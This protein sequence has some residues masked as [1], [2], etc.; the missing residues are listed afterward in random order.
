MGAGRSFLNS[1]MDS[2]PAAVAYLDQELIF[3]QC[4]QAAAREL[5]LPAAEMLGRHLHEVLPSGSRL[6]A[7][8]ESVL[9]SGEP[10]PEPVI[11]D[12]RP[13]GPGGGERHY[14]VGFLPDKDAAGGVRGVFAACQDITDVVE[15]RRRLAEQAQLRL[16]REQMQEFSRWLLEGQERQARAIAMELHDESGQALTALMLALGARS[17]I[18]PARP[19]WPAASPN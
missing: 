13:A 2:V 17:A 14:M 10:F 11:T 19:P 7:A 4:N 12:V 5:G 15:A 3:R 8:M 16:G 6:R 9:R 18:R 1:I